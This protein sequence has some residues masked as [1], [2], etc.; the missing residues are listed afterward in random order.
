VNPAFAAS[1]L[2]LYAGFFT[3]TS[4]KLSNKILQSNGVSAIALQPLMQAFTLDVLGNAMLSFNFGCL[5]NENS[6]YS[7]LYHDL[8]NLAMHPS[9]TYAPYQF[10][11]I[12]PIPSTR[13]LKKKMKSFERLLQNI[14]DSHLANRSKPEF[15]VINKPHFFVRI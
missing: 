13:L 11:D 10:L 3:K 12:L 1:K 7:K 5:K 6:S 15:Q 14:I 8:I 9:R 4:T 2:S